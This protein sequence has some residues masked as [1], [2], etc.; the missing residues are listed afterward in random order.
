MSKIA[1]LGLGAMGA[2]MASRLIE[3]GHEVTVWNRSPDAM[4]P[5]MAKGAQAAR[6]PRDAAEGAAFV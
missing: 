5:L 6:S 3:A 2:R 1:F 4:K